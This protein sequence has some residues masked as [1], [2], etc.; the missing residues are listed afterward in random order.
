MN[1]KK[2]FL[3]N[4]LILFFLIT[5]YSCYNYE[6]FSQFQTQFAPLENTPIEERI[7]IEK[8]FSEFLKNSQIEFKITNKLGYSGTCFFIDDS[9]LATAAHLVEEMYET[10]VLIKNQWEL[11]NLIGI[12]YTKDFALLK[13]ENVNYNIVN[14]PKFKSLESI[15][16]EFGNQKIVPLEKLLVGMKCMSSEKP[17]I[18]I[19]KIFNWNPFAK[20]VSYTLSNDSRGCSGAPIF[21]YDGYVISLHQIQGGL[22]GEGVE[23]N[24]VLN[25]LKIIKKLP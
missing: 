5:S 18:L 17:R 25:A 13:I 21:T 12:S 11:L 20:T 9:T 22:I 16:D 24:E 10:Q 15:F 4:I 8:N 2:Y 3:R 14:P 7:K 1:L 6:N 19:G 23:I